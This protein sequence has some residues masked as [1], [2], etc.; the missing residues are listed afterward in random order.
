MSDFYADRLFNAMERNEVAREH[1][2]TFG[3]DKALQPSNGAR[4]Q[5]HGQRLD[6]LGGH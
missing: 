2:R 3:L 1:M 6:V 4:T 5:R